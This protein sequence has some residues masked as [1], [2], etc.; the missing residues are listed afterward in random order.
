MLRGQ[1]KI[2]QRLASRELMTIE[3]QEHEAE[4]AAAGKKI[5]DSIN[6]FTKQEYDIEKRDMEI[7]G[8]IL[9]QCQQLKS[10]TSET[11][12]KQKDQIMGVSR[13]ILK[14]SN[15]MVRNKMDDEGLKEKASKILERLEKSA[16]KK[17]LQRNSD[18]DSY[19]Q[20]E[21]FNA[22]NHRV[23]QAIRNINPDTLTPLEALNELN[24]LKKIIE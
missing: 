13:S 12:Q 17:S 20:L 14:L 8:Q 16:Q 7:V 22:S 15:K 1:S 10:L 2:K 24:N 9:A 21:I 5:A 6:E 19:E 23:I 18:E 4:I 3:K 11:E